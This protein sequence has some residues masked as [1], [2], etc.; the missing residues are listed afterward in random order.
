M[1]RQR[2]K[3]IIYLQMAENLSRLSTCLDKQVGCILL[4]KHYRVLATGYNGAPKGMDH[5]SDTNYCYKIEDKEPCIAAHAEQNALAQCKDP[6]A[7]HTCITT[8]SPCVTCIS[9]LMNTKCWRI[10]FKQEHRHP[11]PKKRWLDMG[12]EWINVGPYFKRGI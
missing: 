1:E 5:C 4:D 10:V 9:M 12:G 6:D 2:I 11:E 3:D 8:L 7:I